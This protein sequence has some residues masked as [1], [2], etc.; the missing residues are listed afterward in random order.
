MKSWNIDHWQ[1]RKKSQILHLHLGTSSS[2]KKISTC[3]YMFSSFFL[4]S[5]PP[6]FLIHHIKLLI[7]ISVNAKVKRS[8]LDGSALGYH[9]CFIRCALLSVKG[10]FKQSCT[11][12]LTTANRRFRREITSKIS[13]CY[14]ISLWNRRLFLIYCWF[15]MRFNYKIGFRWKFLRSMGWQFSGCIQCSFNRTKCKI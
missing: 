10:K 5:S 12:L 1:E 4:L 7:L 6:R 11:L 2:W 3:T 9:P 15:L 14:C 13:Q 8:W